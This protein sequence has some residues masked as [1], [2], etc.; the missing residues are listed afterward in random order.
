[1]N[2]DRI[3]EWNYDTH[4]G[5]VW[6]YNDPRV[7]DRGKKSYDCVV[8]YDPR[9]DYHY[10]H[11]LKPE[12]IQLPNLLPVFIPSPVLGMILNMLYFI[13]FSGMPRLLL[14]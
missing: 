9:Y 12:V 3:P 4:V 5:R 7:G 6:S 11:S 2:H 14:V 1:M 8:K 13:L 10:V